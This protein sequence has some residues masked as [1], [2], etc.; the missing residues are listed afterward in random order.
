MYSTVYLINDE[1]IGFLGDNEACKGNL[2]GAI[3]RSMQAAASGHR[4]ACWPPIRNRP[5]LWSRGASTSASLSGGSLL[6]DAPFG[7]ATAGAGKIRARYNVTAKRNRGLQL[8]KWK[9][10]KFQKTVH[11]GLSK[12]KVRI[13]ISVQIVLRSRVRPL[14][15]RGLVVLVSTYPSEI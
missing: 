4:Q 3:I 8:L 14:R 15:N 1:A 10:Y 5:A 11:I 2:Q 13:A 12:K 6:S 9:T 7:L